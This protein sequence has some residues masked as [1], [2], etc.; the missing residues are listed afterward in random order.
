M[1]AKAYNK[2]YAGLVEA[3][4]Y[5]KSD[6]GFHSCFCVGPRA[7]ETVCP[8]MR[9]TQGIDLKAQREIESGAEIRAAVPR[10]A[11]CLASNTTTR[12]I[13]ANGGENV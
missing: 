6:N 8:C 12:I 9:R 4:E 1:S 7:G 5:A 11:L 2:I 3:L 10:P 13:A